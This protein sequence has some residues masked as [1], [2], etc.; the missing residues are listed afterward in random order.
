MIDRTQACF[1]TAYGTGQFLSWRVKEQRV[2]SHIQVWEKNDR[3]DGI[4]S[5]SEFT[6]D[7]RRAV[8]I[9][10]N[11]KLLRTKRVGLL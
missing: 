4:F 7:K 11:A 6:W 5:R 9:R 8:Y 10:P 1:D 3:T 2:T